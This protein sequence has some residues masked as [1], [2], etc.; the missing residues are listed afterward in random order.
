MARKGRRTLKKERVGIRIPLRFFN[1]SLGSDYVVIYFFFFCQT[2]LG[3]S[4]G[5]ENIAGNRDVATLEN[6]KI[7]K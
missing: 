5:R 2:G 1:V 3:G 6:I 4:M 7:E